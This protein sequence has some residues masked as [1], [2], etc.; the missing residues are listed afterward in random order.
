MLMAGQRQMR[1]QAQMALQGAVDGLSLWALWG[2]LGWNDVLRR[3]SRIKISVA[4]MPMHPAAA[5]QS[6]AAKFL[7]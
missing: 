5:E 2:K 6:P 7:R 4:Q 1:N 3:R